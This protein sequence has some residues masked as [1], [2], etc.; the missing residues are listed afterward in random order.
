[1]NPFSCERRITATSRRDFLIQSGLGVG[2]FALADLLEREAAAAT[3]PNTNPLAEKPPHFP[4]TAKRVIFFFMQGGP[5]QV[6]TFDPKPV[7]NRLD[8]QPVPP[9]FLGSDLSLAQI[10]VNESKLMGTR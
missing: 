9:S 2:W 4:A 1:M 6:D 7:L 5:S 8:G 3:T 10:K